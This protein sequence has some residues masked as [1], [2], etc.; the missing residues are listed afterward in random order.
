MRRYT[1]VKSEIKKRVSGSACK[2]HGNF[3]SVPTIVTSW[4]CWKKSRTLLGSV[5]EGQTQGKPLPHDWRERQADT[6][7]H[8]SP[9]R[10][11][12]GRHHQRNRFIRQQQNICVTH[13]HISQWDV[14]TIY[15]SLQ[16]QQNVCIIQVHMEQSPRRTAILELTNS[17]MGTLNVFQTLVLPKWI[18]RF[19]VI[20]VKIPTTNW[21]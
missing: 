2:E 3:H 18:Y 9:D 1:F 19:S 20:S 17:R 4:A 12:T 10:R 5:R 15:S 21:F 16:Q 8:G 7:S 13:A 14:R 6:G 11:P